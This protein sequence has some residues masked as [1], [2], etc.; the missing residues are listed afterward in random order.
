MNADR[1]LKLRP[2]QGV[3][4]PSSRLCQMLVAMDDGWDPCLAPTTGRVLDFVHPDGTPEKYGVC[5]RCF[6]VLDEVAQEIERR[7]T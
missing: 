4:D 5:D 6:K 7:K 3:G 2:I 1:P